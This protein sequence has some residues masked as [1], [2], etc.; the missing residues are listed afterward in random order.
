MEYLKVYNV[1]GY[2]E[3]AT[4]DHLYFKKQVHDWG[5]AKVNNIVGSCPYS[6]PPVIESGKWNQVTEKLARNSL[7][8]TDDLSITTPAQGIQ[9]SEVMNYL[10]YSTV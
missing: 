4:C 6:K 9:V 5:D 2:D 7:M 10:N 8:F 3:S 1:A